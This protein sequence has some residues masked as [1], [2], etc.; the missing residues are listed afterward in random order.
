MSSRGKWQPT[1]VSKAFSLLVFSRK[2]TQL[3]KLDHSSNV[4]A[5]FHHSL[6][7][8]DIV[9]NLVWASFLLSRENLEWLYFCSVVKTLLAQHPVW[10][11]LYR[12]PTMATAPASLPACISEGTSWTQTMDPSE[13]RKDTLPHGGL[14]INDCGSH[15]LQAFMHHAQFTDKHV[16]ERSRWEF[17]GNPALLPCAHW[18][19]NT[20]TSQLQGR[21]KQDWG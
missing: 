18:F 3:A 2:A 16:T 9:S 11:D 19:P 5:I 1:P 6:I 15:A 10:E 4:A 14:R 21:D 20:D 8:C 13:Q 7:L 12:P 17:Q